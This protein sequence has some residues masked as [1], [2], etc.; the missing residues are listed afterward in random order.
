MG[1]IRFHRRFKIL[2][3]VWLNFSKGWPSLSIGGHG[4]TTNLSRRGIMT[5]TSIPH[6]GLSYRHKWDVEHHH[7]VHHH[8][9]CLS[10]LGCLIWLIILVGV[11][12]AFSSLTFKIVK[13]DAL[14]LDS[15]AF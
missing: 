11:L 6:S 15:S 12:C 4:L 7:H 2:P 13:T 3:G 5:T 14:G 8:S 1:H 9:G 10:T